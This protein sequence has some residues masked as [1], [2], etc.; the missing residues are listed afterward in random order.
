MRPDEPG[1]VADAKEP[2]LKKRCRML[3]VTIQ[4]MSS[5]RSKCAEC[6]PVY[7]EL[8]LLWS[9]ES[10][11][12]FVGQCP[13]VCR[14]NDSMVVALKSLCRSATGNSRKVKIKYASKGLQPNLSWY[15]DWRHIACLVCYLQLHF[16]CLSGG[17][18]ISIWFWKHYNRNQWIQTCL[19]F[20]PQRLVSVSFLI[21]I[22]R[23]RSEARTRS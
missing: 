20:S 4:A 13:F 8:T 5:K 21:F 14:Y 16:N 1:A 11:C 12:C 19:S 7:D 2:S 15:I 3:Q 17:I 22:A 6:M 10:T 23:R 18:Q 9:T